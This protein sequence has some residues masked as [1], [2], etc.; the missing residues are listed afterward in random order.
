MVLF[1]SITASLRYHHISLRA[2]KSRIDFRVYSAMMVAGNL[3][4][5]C[6][7]LSQYNS[8]LNS[9]VVVDGKTTVLYW[10]W[11][12]LFVSMTLISVC[13]FFMIPKT[14]QPKGNFG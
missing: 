6:S 8:V 2:P 13:Q 5:S 4:L 14:A 3:L 1:A 9:G 10:L 7:V 11:I 12:A